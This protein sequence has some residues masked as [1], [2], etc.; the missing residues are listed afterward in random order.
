MEGEGGDA[1]ATRA[2]GTAFSRILNLPA[3]GARANW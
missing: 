3:L 1:K 2:A